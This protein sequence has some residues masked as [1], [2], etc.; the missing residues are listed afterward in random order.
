MS[1]CPGS[2][3]RAARAYRL[4]WVNVHDS[5]WQP[6]SQQQLLLTLEVEAQALTAAMFRVIVGINAF[7]E[8]D[9]SARGH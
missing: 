9:L 3:R 4:G 7:A 6:A 5:V 8:L 2:S 1:R